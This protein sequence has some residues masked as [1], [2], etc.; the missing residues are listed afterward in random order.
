[1]CVFLNFPEA[2]GVIKSTVCFCANFKN[3]SVLGGSFKCVCWCYSSCSSLASS[4]YF[5]LKAA[6]FAFELKLFFLI[7][8]G[9]T[10]F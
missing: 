2:W 4:L 10:P 1:M 3:L 5:C 9:A 8:Q 7:L 6:E